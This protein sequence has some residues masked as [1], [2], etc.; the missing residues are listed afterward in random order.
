MVEI[1]EIILNNIMAAV[2]QEL[3]TL[4]LQ[5][6]ESTL[7]LNLRGVKLVEECTELSTNTDDN[8]YML[9]VF[10]ANKKLEG[11]KIGSIE[12]YVRYT[13]NFLQQINKNYKDINKDDV[14]FYLAMYSQKVKQ[15]TLVN[16][17]HFL[18]TFFTFVHEEGYISKNPVKTIKGI[19]P[20]EI[21][22]VYLSLEEETA[23]RDTEKSLRDRAIIDFL[24]ST[25]VRVGEL[26]K[27]QLNN[28]NLHNGSITFTGEKNGRE[29]TVYLDVRAKK[30][31]LEYLT[32]RTDDNQAL[33]VTYRKYYNQTT[34]NEEV[35]ACSKS[36]FEDITKS[37]CIKAGIKNKNCTVHVFRK[38][39]ATRLAEQ[40]C[41][42][43][44]IQELLGHSSAG[45]TSKHYIAKSAQRIKR[46]F[47]KY[48]QAA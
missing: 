39:F 32:T 40:G 1:K 34:G 3:T 18:S 26:S 15:N 28:L 19:K 35:K 11:C 38:T 46:E 12:Q 30:H 2:Q 4:Q 43:E 17:K 45:V 8:E 23:V 47:V 9:K 31:L 14:K 36:S 20:V 7:R 10:A 44:I 21:E 24:L 41:P 13:R 5:M 27:M 33:F 22:N 37:I 16:A 42:L 29:R 48:M 25:G 6:L